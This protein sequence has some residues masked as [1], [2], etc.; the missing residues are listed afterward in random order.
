VTGVDRP[1]LQSRRS[2]GSK[3]RESFPGFCRRCS[4][5][6]SSQTPRGSGCDWGPGGSGLEARKRQYST[7]GLTRRHSSALKCVVVAVVAAAVVVDE[8]VTFLSGSLQCA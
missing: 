2:T 7:K 3:R 6:C 1:R 4:R 5:T 8:V